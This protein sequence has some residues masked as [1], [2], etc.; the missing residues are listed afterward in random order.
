MIIREKFSMLSNT[1]SV[2]RTLFWVRGPKEIATNEKCA[3]C[4]RLYKAHAE[5][6]IFFN[7]KVGKPPNDILANPLFIGRKEGEVDMN[8]IWNQ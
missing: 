3:F 2:E 7:E 1:T 4:Y 6:I 8:A 5:L